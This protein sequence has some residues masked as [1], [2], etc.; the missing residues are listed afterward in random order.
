MQ[1]KKNAKI[2]LVQAIL[3]NLVAVEKL[4]LIKNSPNS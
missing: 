2:F 4:Q 3:Y 1:P